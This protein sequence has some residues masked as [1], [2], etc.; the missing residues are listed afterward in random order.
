MNTSQSKQPVYLILDLAYSG[1]L[2][3]LSRDAHVW[4][5]K[6]PANDVA[7]RTV[8]DA[9]VEPY[10]TERGVSCFHWEGDLV[11]GF[12]SALGDIDKHHDAYEADVAW[13]SIFVIGLS[14]E[15]VSAERACE[16]LGFEVL[17]LR[18]EHEGEYF[19]VRRR[20]D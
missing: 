5:L 7:V 14:L 16:T 2:W 17:M 12:Y 6:S 9:E 13:T 15:V 8:W 10:S 18:A 11:G 4:V 20:G 3:A 19:E 1:D